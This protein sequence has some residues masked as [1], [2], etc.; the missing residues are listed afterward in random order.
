[1]MRW[2][3]S[4][5]GMI[6]GLD[7]HIPSEIFTHIGSFAEEL[8]PEGVAA[9][10]CTWAIHPGG[11]MVL[12]AIIDALKIKEKETQSAWDVLRQYGNMSS[13][14]LIFVLNQLSRDQQAG[15]HAHRVFFFF[16]TLLSQVD[17]PKGDG[18]RPWHL[19]PA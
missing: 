1:M 3:L 18:Y 16:E 6:I 5:S 4:K 19:V 14:T 7:K 15:T 17:W 10:D 11:P 9:T 12:R 8:L 13:G 2:E